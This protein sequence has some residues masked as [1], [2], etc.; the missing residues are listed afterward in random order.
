MSTQVD[1]FNI[2]PQNILVDDIFV[3]T[4]EYFDNCIKSGQGTKFISNVV[5]TILDNY[6]DVNN[7]AEKKEKELGFLQILKLFN[8]FEYIT[9]FNIIGYIELIIKT[10][11]Q[12]YKKIQ[13]NFAKTVLERIEE[14]NF[15]LNYDDL[16][17]PLLPDDCPLYSKVIKI[18]TI[19]IEEINEFFLIAIPKGSEDGQIM[20]GR[21]LSSLIN[22]NNIHIY[23]HWVSNFLKDIKNQNHCISYGSQTEYSDN[24]KIVLIQQDYYIKDIFK[25]MKNFIRFVKYIIKWCDSKINNPMYQEN[26]VEIQN[27]LITEYS[28]ISS[29]LNYDIKN[30]I[31]EVNFLGYD[32]KKLANET[33]RGNYG[34]NYLNNFY[35]YLKKYN[36]PILNEL[37]NKVDFNIM[38]DSTISNILTILTDEYKD[39]IFHNLL[40]YSK[41][42]KYYEKIVSYIL[43]KANL[44]FLKVSELSVLLDANGNIL[45]LDKTISEIKNL[46][47][48]IVNN[49]SV[50][51][52]KIPYC[53]AWFYADTYRFKSAG[54]G[55]NKGITKSLL[56][57]TL[58][59]IK[60]NNNIN[61]NSVNKQSEFY[62]YGLIHANALS[63][64]II[65]VLPN[66]FYKFLFGFDITLEE[67]CGIDFIQNL[68]AIKSM[69]QEELTDL[70]LTM[71]VT[72]NNG[73]N[74]SE[75]DLMENGKDIS[76]S[77]DNINSYIDLITQYYT[78][79]NKAAPPFINMN[80]F[81]EGFNFVLPLNN[82]NDDNIRE[83]IY[84][85]LT[86]TNVYP[87]LD[88]T[89]LDNIISCQDKN[90][91]DTIIKYL[92]EC[93]ANKITKFIRLVT[94][95]EYLE[96]GN[97]IIVGKWNTSINHYP[98]IS[99][100]S[101]MMY[102]P[103]YSTY[104]GFM[105]KMDFMI[106][107]VLGYQKY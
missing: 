88:H 104:T 36:K 92:S 5:I 47:Q 74:N 82:V 49:N 41:S 42:I 48:T 80:A 93:D 100:C 35:D 15:T 85:F 101:K 99:T 25:N 68:T 9:T 13:V 63:C 86:C 65:N 51:T 27:W 75:F 39:I 105:E 21:I 45:D 17:N 55:V 23:R 95:L 29:L 22:L 19:M 90:L 31:V 28:L 52:T 30:A 96:P 46:I 83:I 26:V 60:I 79:K 57:T 32:Y 59:K 67:V 24:T 1:S 76:V 12:Y 102:V 7:K 64:F 71:S 81:V 91:K 97:K 78:F 4:Q 20:F 10:F 11:I 8:T 14:L 107:N 18:V 98:K 43:D 54:S 50:K 72:I 37:V 33:F 70:D 3:N 103:P 44:D 89:D 84:K 66:Y 62:N 73:S 106:E 2:L 6:L 53:K 77:I 40:N 61:F 58:N 87:T 34:N 38:H 16:I 56:A 94:S 69:T